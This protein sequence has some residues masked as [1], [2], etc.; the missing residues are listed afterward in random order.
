MSHFF[1]LIANCFFV[2]FLRY[3]NSIYGCEIIDRDLYYSVTTLAHAA[4]HRHT[5][6]RTQSKTLNIT[7]YLVE[8]YRFFKISTTGV[9][10][11]TSALSLI[12][13]TLT[14]TQEDARETQTLP[15][16]SQ[17]PTL[18]HFCT[19]KS[20][21]TAQDFS[22]CKNCDDKLYRHYNFDRMTHS[23]TMLDAHKTLG[24][25]IFSVIMFTADHIYKKIRDS[26]LGFS[27]LQS[28]TRFFATLLFVS[29][30]RIWTSRAHRQ[31]L[32]QVSAHLTNDTT[33]KKDTV[34]DPT[35]A[36]SVL[37]KGNVTPITP[38]QVSHFVS[39]QA[40]P[41]PPPKIR[42]GQRQFATGCHYVP[43]TQPPA[44]NVKPLT[45]VAQHR[46]LLDTRRSTGKPFV[47]MLPPHSHT[48]RPFL[49]TSDHQRPGRN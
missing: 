47:R 27:N 30:D 4:S 8:I 24:S 12:T 36:I 23:G 3:C 10:A 25:D 2:I 46:T 29:C 44:L 21:V 6:A 15:D 16:D 22:L 33:L 40:I 35:I 11:T 14:D 18:G 48:V 31:I 28:S 17:L 19:Y 20:C 41:D 42:P 45:L 49:R 26:H 9:V 39:T 38:M 34:R 37:L 7:Q 43:K 32:Q 13:V 5:T 1:K